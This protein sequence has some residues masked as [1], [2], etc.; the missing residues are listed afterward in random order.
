MPTQFIIGRRSEISSHRMPEYLFGLC[1][2]EIYI[3]SMHV[4]DV[5]VIRV[6]LVIV[7]MSPLLTKSHGS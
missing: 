5:W 1:I 6:G 3:L 4:A 2:A 7:G